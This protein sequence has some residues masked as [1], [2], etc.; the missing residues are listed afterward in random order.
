MSVRFWEPLDSLAHRC[1]RI[2]PPRLGRWICDRLDLAYGCTRTELSNTGPGG[3]AEADTTEA[4]I[5][6]MMAAAQPV[7][8]RESDEARGY[9]QL[10]ADP[11]RADLRQRAR[12]RTPPE[13]WREDWDS[14]EDGAYD[15]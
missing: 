11:E 13:A 15:A 4:G 8:L 10:A 7:S 1:K 6:A 2:V 14:P 3:M 9:A 5:D 12:R